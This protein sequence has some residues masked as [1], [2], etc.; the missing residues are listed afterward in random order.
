MPVYVDPN[1]E[2]PKT[3]KWP[4]GSVSH[5]YADTPEEL[6]ELAT[7]IGLK[8][9]WCSDVTQPDSTLLH[10]DLSPPKRKQAIAA[11]AIPVDHGHGEPYRLRNVWCWPGFVK[12]YV[13]RAGGKPDELHPD[14]Y[15]AWR[16]L[17][18]FFVAGAVY[19]VNAE[20]ARLA[21][22]KE[23]PSDPRRDG[24]AVRG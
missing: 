9:D 8:R 15:P 22:T 3:K 6:H 24:S 1:F 4:Y 18:R 23:T 16:R 13:E 20:R 14:N 10:Y 2:W 5:M 11:G 12:H 7:K 19:G 17:W 21:K